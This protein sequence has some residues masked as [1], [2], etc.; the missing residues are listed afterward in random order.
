V[1]AA[2]T[3]R[4]SDMSADSIGKAL[5]HPGERPEEVMAIEAAA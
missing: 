5:V 1:H 2:A 3:P 4:H